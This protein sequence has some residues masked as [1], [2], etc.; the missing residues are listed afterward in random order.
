MRPVELLCE[1]ADD[2]SARRIGETL[3]LLEVFIQSSSRARPFE[4]CAHEERP[5][6]R[7]VD[8]DQVT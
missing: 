5:L 1:L 7:N 6:D 3:Q 8:G 2:D 4:R